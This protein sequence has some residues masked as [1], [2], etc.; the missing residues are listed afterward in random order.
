MRMSHAF[1]SVLIVMMMNLGWTKAKHSASDEYG[2]AWEKTVCKKDEDCVAP[3][4]CE[5]GTPGAFVCIDKH[6]EGIRRNKKWA[7]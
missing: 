7:K 1:L 2:I 6:G 4:K 5:E 3:G